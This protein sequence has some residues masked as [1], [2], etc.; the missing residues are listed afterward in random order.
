MNL[1]T[2]GQIFPMRKPSITVFQQI[3]ILLSEL[4]IISLSGNV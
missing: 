3:T 2:L 1:L 4:L